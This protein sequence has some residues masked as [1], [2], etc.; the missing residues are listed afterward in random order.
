MPNV[1]HIN[2]GIDYCAQESWLAAW[3]FAATSHNNQKFSGTDLPYL[4]HIGM[5]VMEVLSAH[6]QIPIDDISLAVQCAILHDTMEDQGVLH[7]TLVGLFNLHV[8]EGVA[9]LTKKST[10]PSHDALIDSIERIQLQP[11]AVWCV[12]LAD[13]ISNLQP[14]PGHWSPEKIKKYAIEAREILNALGDANTILATRLEEKIA[15]YP[16]A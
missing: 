15:R 13:R 9:A 10:L 8:A 12:K 5:V 14:P 7:T 1:K 16:Q 4:T 2:N 11:K 3:R 6:A